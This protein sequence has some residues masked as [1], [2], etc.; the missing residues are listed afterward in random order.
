MSP[1]ILRIEHYVL[2]PFI[3]ALALL[4]IVLCPSPLAGQATE[5]GTIVGTVIDSQN[6]LVPGAD[7]KVTNTGRN[8]TREIKTDSQG[9][10]AARSLVPGSYSV[11]VT[12]PSF[13]KQV[14]SDIKLDLG[15]TVTLD[16]HLTVGQVTEQIQVK[17]ESV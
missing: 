5:L 2:A 7:V 1:M 14:Q 3:C 6:A 11:E 4:S 8:V 15:A 16:F 12:A 13:Q 17:A 9:A 10:F